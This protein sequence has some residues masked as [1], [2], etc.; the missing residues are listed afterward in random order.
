MH[1]IFLRQDYPKYFAAID[2]S[3]VLSVDDVST[4]SATQELLASY[5]NPLGITS[6]LD[7]PIIIE[8]R[9]RGVLCHEH[10]GPK[11]AWNP[12]ETG[13]VASIADLIG[14]AILTD[15]LRQ[16]RQ[17]LLASE[18]RAQM[19][20][21]KNPVALLVTDDEGRIKAANHKAASLFRTSQ[22]ELENRQVEELIPDRLRGEHCRHRED[23]RDSPSHRAM[24]SSRELVAKAVDHTEFPAE[25]GLCPIEID[26]AP[27]VICAITDISE[28]KRSESRLR[29]LSAAIEQAPVTMMILDAHGRIEYANPHFSHLTG[30]VESRILGKTLQDLTYDQTAAESLNTIWA[31]LDQGNSWTGE[32]ATLTKSGEPLWEEVHVAPV[33]NEQGKVTHFV[34]I[35]LNISHRKQQE[36]MLRHLAMHDQLT[37][38]PN[39]AL[40]NDRLAMSMQSA[41]RNSHQLALM[42]I[43]LDYFKEINDIHGHEV[44]D[45]VLKASAQR[46]R[47]ELRGTDTVARIGGDEFVLLIPNVNLPRDALNVAE[48][49]RQ[50]IRIPIQTSVKE[51]HITCSIGIALYPQQASNE[52]EL[53]RHAD[54][55]L[56]RVKAAGRDAVE[57]Y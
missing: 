3:R 45:E 30:F 10:T 32:L 25:I 2:N 37:D 31:T 36:A 18:E 56:Y 46:M 41:R 14:Q 17:K 6:M 21:F 11:R 26:G 42:F 52:I 43:D 39:R 34:A 40:L 49:V 54:Q 12:L 23:Y 19:M 9:M 13:F 55:A 15:E 53:Y 51:M 27:H 35:K 50:A 28:R 44:G 16:T 4:H 48:K 1:A 8:G 20:F 22:Q 24:D 38:L 57:L 5:L 47:A 29:A 7:V 33:R